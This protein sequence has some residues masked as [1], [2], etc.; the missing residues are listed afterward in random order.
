MIEEDLETGIEAIRVLAEEIG[1]RPSASQEEAAAALFVSGRLTDMGL[2]PQTSEFRSARSFGPAYLV[3]FGL[4]AGAGLMRRG[5][6]RWIAG[7]LAAGL[8]LAA[9]RFSRI[10]AASVTKWRRSRNVTATVEPSGRAERTVCLVSHLD[11]S[12]SGLMFHPAVTPVLGNVVAL[13]GVA[14]MSQAL[15]PLIGRRGIGKWF[16][17]KCRAVCAIAFGLV[18]QRE[19]AGQDVA[20]ANDNASGVGAC[21]ALASRFARDPLEGSRIV[22][23]FTGSEESGVH[24]MS[25]FLRAHDTEGWLFINFDGVSADEPLRVLS[26]EG[27]PLGSVDADPELIERT[28]DVG[29]KTPELRAVPLEHGSGLPYDATPVLMAGGRA[30]SVV[31]QDGA[32]PDY[33]WPTDRFDRVSHMAFERAV[34]FGEQL[35]LE[36]DRT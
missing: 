18:L 28:A 27:G 9:G 20:G 32:I 35:V 4:A 26:K 3:T 17:W 5:A 14:L 7:A 19:V 10:G 23:L 12:R 6:P 33:H 29:R 34:S 24:G 25:E 31:N 15:D 21:L 30:I 36:I 13:T 8:G 1:P 11:S 22:L 2:A 16:V